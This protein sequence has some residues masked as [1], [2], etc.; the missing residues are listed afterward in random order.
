MMTEG[1][2]LMLY[3][4]TPL[5]MGAI[6]IEKSLAV[7]R[8]HYGVIEK[9]S[10][11]V[12]LLRSEAEVILVDS[13]PPRNGTNPLLHIPDYVPLEEALCKAG[14]KPADVTKIILT[15]LHYDHCYNLELFPQAPVY[16][17][18][19]EITSAVAPAQ[20]LDARFYGALPGNGK[21]GWIEGWGRFLVLDGDAEIVPGVKVYLAPG[22]SPGGQSVLVDTKEGHWLVAGD[23]IPKYECFTDGVP[24]GTHG[25]LYEWYDS[26]KKLKALTEQCLPSHDISVFKCKVYG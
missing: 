24:N 2:A 11:A 3:T 26:Y 7:Y 18:R 8:R 4:I 14:V 13:G 17:Q 6:E 25:N 21:P 10:F 16:V 22:H 23:F 9:N 20:E 1:G 5:Y 15:H 19:K 12:F